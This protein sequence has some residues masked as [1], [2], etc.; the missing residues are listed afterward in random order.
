MSEIKAAAHALGRV[1]SESP[2]VKSI[3]A[4]C[5]QNVHYVL[6]FAHLLATLS[7][8]GMDITP[9]NGGKYGHGK[10][11]HVCRVFLWY[12]RPTKF[13]LTRFNLHV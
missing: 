13:T 4:E 9:M 8:G 3:A 12:I 1:Q 6:L 5:N 10:W 7:M 11:R 2:L